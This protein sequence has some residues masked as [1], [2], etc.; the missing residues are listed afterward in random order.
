MR[1]TYDNAEYKADDFDEDQVDDTDATSDEETTE[2]VLKENEE[3]FS[4]E[5]PIHIPLYLTGKLVPLRDFSR[6]SAVLVDELDKPLRRTDYSII[7]SEGATVA[8]G[9]QM[10][11]VQSLKTCYRQKV[12]HYLKTRLGKFDIAS[13]SSSI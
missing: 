4:G 11:M 6:V 2:I 10:I 7:D 12:K 13:T 8:N 1:L 9:K 5:I 3:A